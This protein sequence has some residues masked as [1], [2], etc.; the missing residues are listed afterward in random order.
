[1]SVQCLELLEWSALDIV[2][3]LPR[4]SRE[5]VNANL[6]FEIVSFPLRE[7]GKIFSRHAQLFLEV[8]VTHEVLSV[9]HQVIHLKK[10]LHSQTFNIENTGTKN[11]RPR[12][13]M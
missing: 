11:C 13:N 10:L 9:K 2:C 12:E 5:L 8:I 6:L 3:Q 7:G 4:V 1:M